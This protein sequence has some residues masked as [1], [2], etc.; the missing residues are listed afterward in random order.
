[1]YEAKTKP[2]GVSVASY[3]AA[4]EDE[5][6]RRDCAA[7]AALLERLTGC[8]PRMWGTSIVGFDS[9]HYR[10]ASGHEGD[11]CAVGFSSRKREITVYLLGGFEDAET[12]KLLARLGKHKT[13]KGCLY[14]RRLA[15]IELPVLERLVARSLA[16]TRRRYP[17]AQA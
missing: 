13:G 1:V 4:I 7:L 10:Y 5:E 2:T 14:L 3:L 6:R 12:R 11:S 9:Y 16:E 15:D 17:K 8:P